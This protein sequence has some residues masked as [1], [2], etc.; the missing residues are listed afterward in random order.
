L[1]HDFGLRRQPLQT[2]KMALAQPPSWRPSK[3]FLAAR[4]ALPLPSGF[5]LGDKKD[6][7]RWSSYCSGGEGLDC[8]YVLCF[9]VLCAKF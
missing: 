7:R 6:R 9:R 5:V 8:L 4:I 2:S 1:S 3:G